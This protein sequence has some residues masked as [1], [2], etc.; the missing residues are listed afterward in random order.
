MAATYSNGTAPVLVAFLAAAEDQ[1]LALT[2][3]NSHC[4]AI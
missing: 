4:S 2:D 3:G 1:M